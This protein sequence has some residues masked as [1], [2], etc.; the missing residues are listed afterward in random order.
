MNLTS[1]VLCAFLLIAL[2]PAGITNFVLLLISGKTM[3]IHAIQDLDRVLDSQKVMIQHHLHLDVDL[4]ALIQSRTQLRACWIDYLETGETVYY[5]QLL[6]I[7]TDIETALKNILEV[8]LLDHEGKVIISTKPENINLIRAGEKYL[9]SGRKPEQVYQASISEDQGLAHYLT[10]PL[11]LDNHVVGTVLV[12]VDST[13]SLLLDLKTDFLWDSQEVFLITEEAEEYHCFIVSKEGN[14]RVHRE[15]YVPKSEGDNPYLQLI[16]SPVGLATKLGDQQT[17][18]LIAIALPIEEASS[19]L[20]IWVKQDEVFKDLHATRY[21]TIA[22]LLIY[23]VTVTIISIYFANSLTLPIN[24]LIQTARSI[25]QG[26]LTHRVV[27]RSEDEIGE[28]A[29]VINHMAANL[30]ELYDNLDNLVA[31]RTRTLETEILE[32]KTSEQKLRLSEERYHATL[33]DAGD[34]IVIVDFAGRVIE[35]NRKAVELFKVDKAELA[36]RRYTDFFPVDDASE[37]IAAFT[38]VI[39]RGYGDLPEVQ[40][41]TMQGN[42]LWVSIAATVLNWNDQK[43]VQAIIHNIT[44]RK[45]AEEQNARLTEDLREQTQQLQN[46]KRYLEGVNFSI[47]HDLLAHLRGINGYTSLLL[48]ECATRLDANGKQYLQRVYAL[49]LTMKQLL[50]DLHAY[51][52]IGIQELSYS[53]I[54]MK[55]LATQCMNSIRADCPDRV[56]AFTLGDL[57]LAYG[58]RGLLK[59]LLKHLLSNAVKFTQIRDP[60]KIKLDGYTTALE[61]VFYVVDNGIGFNP[62]YLTQLFNLLGQLHT[63]PGYRGSGV[64]LASVKAIVERHHGSVWAKSTEDQGA[65]FYFSLPLAKPEVKT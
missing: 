47:S 9:P 55:A 39:K 57:P 56:I 10:G 13:P 1:K 27:I 31:E 23:A 8:A 42:R 2:I 40:L 5:D 19:I 33:K 12:V 7:L 63:D 58:D 35:S 38:E 16:N 64:G 44:E 59:Q 48:D 34:A 37:G 65:I 21:L 14:G 11:I 43:V 4:L 28:L 17:G 41:Q 53:S 54:D 61:T 52:A 6:T 20:G 15:E 29:S 46:A 26:K 32:R 60:A 50:E 3:R 18:P 36:N 45:A 51:F 62:N 22:L 49:T 30:K 25:G 24:E